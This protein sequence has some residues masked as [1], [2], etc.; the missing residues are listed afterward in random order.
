M[1]HLLRVPVSSEVSVSQSSSS[2]NSGVET[3]LVVM[4]SRFSSMSVMSI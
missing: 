1:V 2:D 4:V 3:G